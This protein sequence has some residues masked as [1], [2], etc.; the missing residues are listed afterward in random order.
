MSFDVDDNLASIQEL[1]ARIAAMS[2]GPER[3]VLAAE[4]DKLRDGARLAADLTRPRPHLEAELANVRSQLDQMG[5]VAIKPA[6]NESYKL[7]TDPSA[8]RRRINKSIQD[9]EADRRA[10]LE[11][12]RA[13][14]VTALAALQED[15]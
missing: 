6:L 3:D 11:Q 7:I 12:R 8:Y 1:S 9:N 13:E 4:R 2:H 14:L 15:L 10:A 5:E